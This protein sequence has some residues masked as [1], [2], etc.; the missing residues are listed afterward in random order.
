MGRSPDDLT[1][2]ER[3]ELVGKFIAMEIYTPAALPMRRIEAI[4]DSIGECV[5]MLK[6]RGLEPPRFEYSRLPPPY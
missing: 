3:I 4:G 2:D 5:R 6:G 1:L